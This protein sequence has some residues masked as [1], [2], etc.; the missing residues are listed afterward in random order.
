MKL[1]T[2]KEAAKVLRVSMSFLEKDRAGKQ[3]IPVVRIGRKV[4]YELEAIE[5]L[6]V[7]NM[8]GGWNG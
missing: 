8:K 1:L 4:R 3:E 5:R 2:T 6:I 7:A